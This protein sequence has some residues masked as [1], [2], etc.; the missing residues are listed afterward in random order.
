MKLSNKAALSFFA[1]ITAH[2]LPLTKTCR[3]WDVRQVLP[4][5]GIFAER[6][7][8]TIISTNV[9]A[10]KMQLTTDRDSRFRR[11]RVYV[12]GFAVCRFFVKY[13]MFAYELRQ[14]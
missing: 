13:C 12:G 7:I 11:E 5:D 6:C 8:Y 3:Q 4:I 2:L 1:E 10:L 9:L 14:K